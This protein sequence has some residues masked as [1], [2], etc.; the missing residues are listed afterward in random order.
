ML[1]VLDVTDY[2]LERLNLKHPTASS[3][4]D[5]LLLSGPVIKANKIIFHSISQKKLIR[6]AA[7]RTKGAAGP[8]RFDTYDW[9]H[10]ACSNTFENHGIVEVSLRDFVPRGNEKEMLQFVNFF[11]ISNR[12]VRRLDGQKIYLLI[13]MFP[14]RFA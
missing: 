6:K 5:N 10:I 4:L 14:E 3:K 13:I 11:S 12:K 8:S 7:I 2:I 1:S 9:Q